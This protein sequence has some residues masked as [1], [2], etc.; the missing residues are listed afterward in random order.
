MS[1]PTAATQGQDLSPDALLTIGELAAHTGLT[2]E[3]LRT[4]EARHGFPEPTRLPSGHRRYTGADVLAVRRVVEERERGVRLE[5]AI[6]A[7]RSAGHVEET[8]SVY[9]ALTARHPGLTSYTLS[10]RTLLALSWAIEDESAAQANRAVLVGTFQR[11]RYFGQS[12][13]RWE[14]MARTARAAVVM[15]DFPAHDDRSA[16]ARVALPADSP[17]LREWIVVC[18]GPGLTAVLVAWELPGQEDLPES[19]RLFEAVWTVDSRVVR[20]AAVVAAEAAAAVGSA[21]GVALQRLLEDAPPPVSTNPR[22]AT[23]VFNRMV[24]YTDGTVLRGRTRL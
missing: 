23:S 12:Q 7:A 11:G 19:D 20:D 17:L 21:S 5:Q 1:T 24:A 22:A 10:K 4:W 3:V 2:P 18:D 16:P 6:G 13:K 9:A 15:A 14:E 8:G